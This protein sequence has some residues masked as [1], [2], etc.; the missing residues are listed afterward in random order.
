MIGP[1]GLNPFLGLGKESKHS[2]LSACVGVLDQGG[3]NPFLGF[4]S[5]SELSLPSACVGVTGFEPST[6]SSRT[7]RATK[8]RHT[9]MLTVTPA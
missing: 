6:S 8:L 1:E 5:E 9:P 3:L 4:G 7:K 2:L